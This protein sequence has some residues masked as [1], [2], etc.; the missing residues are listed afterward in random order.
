MK[1]PM[2]LELLQRHW[3]LTAINLSLCIREI[4]R[5]IWCHILLMKWLNLEINRDLLSIVLSLEW[6]AT[7]FNK[8]DALNLCIKF[9]ILRLLKSLFE[10]IIWTNISNK[11][12]LKNRH[13]N[14]KSDTIGPKTNKESSYLATK[15]PCLNK[16]SLTLNYGQDLVQ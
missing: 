5:V 2:T 3:D 12:N 6:V 14:T 7:M 9:R 16:F 4:S 15:L 10:I 1:K 8:Q 11:W 13:L